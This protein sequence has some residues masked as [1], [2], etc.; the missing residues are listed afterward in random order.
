[1]PQMKSKFSNL[2]R[3]LRDRLNV[4]A[5]HGLRDRDPAAHLEKLREVSLALDQEYEGLRSGLPARLNH[6][7]QSRS[8][9]KAL[10]FIEDAHHGAVNETAG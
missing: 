3:L 2:E 8:Y 9:Q 5:D 10:A 6:F 4:I 7:M 1:M